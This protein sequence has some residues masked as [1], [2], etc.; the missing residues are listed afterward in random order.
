MKMKRRIL[1]LLLLLFILGSHLTV[2]AADIPRPTQD[3][4]VN[5]FAGV[6]SEA[7]KSHILQAGEQLQA[8]T[9]AQV[10]VVTMNSIGQEDIF[11]FSLALARDWGIGDA[12]RNN[13]CLIF[14]SM[15]DRQSYVQVGYGLEGRLTDSKTGRLQDDYLIPYMKEGD[16]SAG[17]QNLF[18][19]IVQEVY[20]EYAFESPGNIQP[21][22]KEEPFDWSLV[23]IGAVV[24]GLIVFTAIDNKTGWTQSLKTGDSDSSYNGR[25]GGGSSGS[26]GGSSGG[27]GSF[28]GGGSGRSW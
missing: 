16:Y 19:A 25:R 13:G 27:G 11:N 14:L 3:F 17:I 21:Q 12:D 15:A 10:V 6:L 22:K 24:V 26:S 8:Q 18:D 7:T 28:G 2:F 23:I 20:T 4:Y 5:D 1:S 9:T